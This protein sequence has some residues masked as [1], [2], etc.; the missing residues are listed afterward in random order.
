MRTPGFGDNRLSSTSGVW[1]IAWTM[2]PY[3]PPQGRFSS[4]GPSI[5]SERIAWRRSPGA[6]D[7]AGA[8]RALPAGH[9]RQDHERVPLV[10]RRVEPLQDADVLVVQ[11][12]VHVPVE[13]PVVAEQLVRGLGVLLGQRAQHLADVAALGVDL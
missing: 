13:R 2:S 4:S 1:P 6:S 7:A 11:V 3:L 8:L 9:R 5:A 12:H 10:D